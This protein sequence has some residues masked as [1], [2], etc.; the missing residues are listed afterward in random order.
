M[1]WYFLLI[2]KKYKKQIKLTFKDC[3][4]HIIK[5]FL[6]IKNFDK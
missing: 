5:V 2:L 6:E 4:L 1:I 3:Y